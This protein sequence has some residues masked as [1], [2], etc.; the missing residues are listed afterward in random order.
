MKEYIPR[1]DLLLVE[2]FSTE[3]KLESGI[4]LQKSLIDPV[5]TRLKVIKVGDAVHDLKAG[6]IV[7]AEDTFQQI[8]NLDKNLGLINS[9]YVHA[10]ERDL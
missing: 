7:L 8:N 5:F 10:I 4:F 6:D 1:N 9:K 2:K 3:E